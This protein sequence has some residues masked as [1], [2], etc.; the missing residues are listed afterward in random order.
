MATLSPLVSASASEVE[1]A[2]GSCEEK[3][4]VQRT[5]SAADSSKVATLATNT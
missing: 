1:D 3:H 2:A 5:V 4:A